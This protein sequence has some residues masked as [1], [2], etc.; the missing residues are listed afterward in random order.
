MPGSILV[1]NIDGRYLKNSLIEL[2]KLAQIPYK[3][4]SYGVTSDPFMDLRSSKI[5]QMT[6]IDAL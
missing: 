6:G 4:F 5:K 2:T 1:A 3:A